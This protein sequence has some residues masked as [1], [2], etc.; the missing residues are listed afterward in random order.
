MQH[1]TTNIA[2]SFPKGADADGE[3]ELIATVSEAEGEL[4]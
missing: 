4:C 1:Q 3:E 2:N